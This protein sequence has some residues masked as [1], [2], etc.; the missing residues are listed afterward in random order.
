[1]AR[2]THDQAWSV[3][4]SKARLSELL[5]QVINDGPQTI[6]RRGEAIAVVVSIEEWRRKSERPGSLAEF[7]AA[8]PLRDSDL[9]INR[10]D[11]TA[12]D[13]SL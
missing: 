12:R 4:D 9:E 3:A 1:M 2:T 6:T 11:T 8:S 13:V 5:E 10:I 7:L